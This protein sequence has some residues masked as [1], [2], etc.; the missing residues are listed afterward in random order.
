[1]STI[2]APALLVFQKPHMHQSQV[3]HHSF[4]M[5]LDFGE[6]QSFPLHFDAV[7]CSQI[8][9]IWGLMELSSYGLDACV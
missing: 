2:F 7:F 1:M 8:A 6:K 3:L 9:C 5:V 4:M